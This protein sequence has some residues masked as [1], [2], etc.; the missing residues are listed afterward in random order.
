MIERGAS[1]ERLAQQMELEEDKIIAG[2]HQEV[3][4]EKYKA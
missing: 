4:K 3:H 2:F 1:Q